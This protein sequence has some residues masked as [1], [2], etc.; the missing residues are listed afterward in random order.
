MQGMPCGRPRHSASICPHSPARGCAALPLHTLLPT[1]LP[2]LG[3]ASPGSTD[4]NFRL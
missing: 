3:P 1:L 2:A 4:T